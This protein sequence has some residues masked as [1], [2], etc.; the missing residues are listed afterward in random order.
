MTPKN[1]HSNPS[2]ESVRETLNIA[3]TR[4][5]EGKDDKAL[6]LY[7]A[8]LEALK[9]IREGSEETI[10]LK[11]QALYGK[12]MAFSSKGLYREAFHTAEQLMD[13]ADV[14]NLPEEKYKGAINAVYNLVNGGDHAKMFNYAQKA[15]ETAIDTGQANRQLEALT[16]MGVHYSLDRSYRE[17]LVYYKKACQRIP[18]CTNSKLIFDLYRWLGALNSSTGSYDQAAE[19]YRMALKLTENAVDKELEALIYN[20]LTE[21]YIYW[22][23]YSEAMTYAQKSLAMA[24]NYQLELWK[25]HMYENYARILRGLNRYEEAIHYLQKGKERVIHLLPYHTVSTFENQLGVTRRMMGHYDK[26]LEH[27]NNYLSILGD[28]KLESDVSLYQYNSGYTHYLK[29][30]FETAQSMLQEA[31]SI[32][33][34]K[35][36][37]VNQAHDHSKMGLIDQALGKYEQAGAHFEK[38]IEIHETVNEKAR[39]GDDYQNMGV[40]FWD[41]QQFHQAEQHLIKAREHIKSSPN[42]T[43]RANYFFTTG[44]F[45]AEWQKPLDAYDHIKQ[46]VQY[47][48]E[49]SL[50]AQ[51]AYC[52][53]YLGYIELMK[54]DQQEALYYFDQARKTMDSPNDNF[55]S[56]RI[57][58]LESFTLRQKNLQKI[59]QAAYF[60]ENA[61]RLS[62]ASFL[63]DLA[64]SLAGNIGENQQVCELLMRH[65]RMLYKYGEHEAAQEKLD[66]AEESLQ[67][68]CDEALQEEIHTLQKEILA[69]LQKTS[70]PAIKK[71][72]DQIKSLID[73]AEKFMDE[74]HDARAL[75]C[76]EKALRIAGNAGEIE[77]LAYAWLGAGDALYYLSERRKS[78][79]NYEMAVKIYASL[80]EYSRVAVIYDTIAHSYNEMNESEKAVE[81]FQSAIEYYKKVDDEEGLMQEYNNLG[82]AWNKL[83]KVEASQKC[84]LQ[85]LAY[86]EKRSDQEYIASLNHNLGMLL[87]ENENKEKAVPYLKKAISIAE[88]QKMDGKAA[89]FYYSLGYICHYYDDPLNADKYYQ[90]GASRYKSLSRQTDNLYDAVCYLEKALE[91]FGRKE[92]PTEQLKLLH[93]LAQHYMALGDYE[94]SQEIV[95][96]GISLADEKGNSEKKA[97]FYRL[98]G[99]IYVR[100]NE[101]E[102]SIEFYRKALNISKKLQDTRNLGWDHYYI[103]E[104]LFR[105]GQIEEGLNQG[106][107]AIHFSEMAD[108][109]E[110]LALITNNIALAYNALGEPEKA[111]D[112]FVQSLRLLEKTG[113]INEMIL[114][115]QN[116]AYIYDRL[117]DAEKQLS[118]LQQVVDKA[119]AQDNPAVRAQA[120]L[121]MGR[122]F[123]NN[124]QFEKAIAWYRKAIEWSDQDHHPETLA[125]CYND[126]AVTFNNM[127]E[128]QKALQTLEKALPITKYIS[129][130]LISRMY[131]NLGCFCEQSGNHSRALEYYA[132]DLEIQ[133]EQ[134]NEANICDAYNRLGMAELNSGSY[135]SAEKSFLNGI[136]WAEKGLDKKG[137]MLSY[138]NMG[139]VKASLFQLHESFDY[140]KK[141]MELASELDNTYMVI[142]LF[143]HT[144]AAYY[145]SGKYKKAMYHLKNA[146][147]LALGSNMT[148]SFP[149]M[150]ELIDEINLI[151]G[152][153]LDIL[154]TFFYQESS[155]GTAPPATDDDMDACMAALFNHD[156]SIPPDDYMDFLGETDGLKWN[157]VTFFGTGQIGPISS[158]LEANQ[159][160]NDRPNLNGRPVLGAMDED[161]IIFDPQEQV[162]QIVA[163]IDCLE[164]ERFNNLREMLARLTGKGTNGDSL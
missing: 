72:Q 103:A 16:W 105:T 78:I 52:Y 93:Q 68:D 156:F 18:Q 139:M 53:F 83:S 102:K 80:R 158:L 95:E 35:G 65:A 23:D 90:E 106:Q 17:A 55:F 39:L 56:H 123:S 75:R 37:A 66:E 74:H 13:L 21:L 108:D 81:A 151:T 112:Y 140:Y 61:K 82:L 136:D 92:D 153:N 98:K 59:K 19:Y 85:A 4:Y 96:K 115:L 86:A 2:P 40:L 118:C 163:R 152:M 150:Y 76:Y 48:G 147:S 29:G 77:S 3:E 14:Y 128:T 36:D 104:S 159:Y 148:T 162:Y 116:L 84:Y 157:G 25:G 124:D 101:D 47:Y 160:Y 122:F 42:P 43:A 54:E 119:N 24:D 110:A 6:S 131:I 114:R 31:L 60:A 71:K 135:D 15:Y 26:A 8:A 121:E 44:M 107:Q 100:L 164:Y 137:L 34:E 33:Q 142:L 41:R 127:G 7:N 22:E 161:L 50:L 51:K 67:P 88:D 9:E 79:Q 20:D 149:A 146:E 111:A 113:E 11:S 143:Y 63:F 10:E 38:S 130:A 49:L 30:D 94:K 1:T 109:K 145:Q 27:F 134:E 129:T 155:I 64:T 70:S 32:D 99:D 5:E 138:K 154:N 62:A 69:Y 45:Y 12:I 58:L 91:G 73:A 89:Y 87:A 132:A 97:W 57:A 141:A 28:K 120:N 117:E 144:G 126:L 46:A 133:L 125:T